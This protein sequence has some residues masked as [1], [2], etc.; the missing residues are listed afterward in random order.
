M[1]SAVLL[2]DYFDNAEKI[3]TNTVIKEDRM[4]YIPI[5][6][7]I[8][9]LLINDKYS[10]ISDINSI[11]C[12]NELRTNLVIYTLYSRKLTTTIANAVHEKFGKYV[13]MRSIIPGNQYEVIYNMRPII[14][15]YSITQY[16]DLDIHTLFNAIKLSDNVYYL[17]V[18]VELMDIY[19]KLYLP[20]YA[21]DYS[22]L[23]Q[24]EQLLWDKLE[25]K[26]G[27]CNTCKTDRNIDITNLRL[28]FLEFLHN[29][30]FVIIGEWCD[31][32]LNN[33]AEPNSCIQIISE[34]DI[35]FDYKTISTFLSKYTKFGI[36]YKKR[37]LYVPKN[38]RILKHTFYIKYPSMSTGLSKNNSGVDKPFLDIYNTCSYEIVPYTTCTHKNKTFRIGSPTLL[39]YF[40]W[41]DL[42]LLGIFKCTGSITDI[43]YNELY[44]LYM[45]YIKKNR[46]LIMNTTNINY[47]Y[48]GINYDENVFQ[49]IDISEKNLKK[50]TY[51]PELSIKKD[52]TYELIA[53]S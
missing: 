40:N 15:V 7:H 37:R 49:K 47:V 35:D 32:I 36:F 41:L 4:I 16:K 42:W 25:K 6:N 45:G 14:S 26:G 52:K 31:Y 9:S 46:K 51:Y 30:N 11:L 1:L 22:L 39:I 44:L 34:N 13:Q 23:K 28:I 17:P 50:T 43:K 5:Y 3:A 12:K 53:T 33:T 20:N 2:T 10:M 18:S 48:T 19:H 8:I 27:V 38:N 21:K 29:E 24:Q